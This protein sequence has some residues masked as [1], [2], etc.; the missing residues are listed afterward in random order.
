MATQHPDNAKKLPWYPRPI[1]STLAELKECFLCFKDL[2]I[3]EYNWDWEGKF[4]D[5]AVVDRLLHNQ[6]NYFSQ[7]PLGQEKF[8]TFRIPNPR[9]ESQFRLARAFM[10]AIT[11]SQHAKSLG[12]DIP[13]IFEAI[14]PLT[15]T[16][17]DIL[18][19][20]EAFVELVG[21]RHPLLKMDHSIRQLEIIPLFE[22]VSI[23]INS[24]D[25]LRR[26]LRLYKKR[27][28][29][30][31]KYI[32]PYIARSDPALNS[33]IVPTVLASKI[34]L[35]AYSKL[36]KESGVKMYPMIGTGSL[37]FRG[38]MNPDNI[39]N[40]I[41][42]YKGVATFTLQS[43]FRY[44]YPKSDVKKAVQFLKSHIPQSP[45]EV[46]KK[47]IDEIKGLLPEF[48]APYRQGVENLAPLI[49]KIS[50]NF[51]K[52]RERLQHIG[53]FG[54]SR[55]VGKVKLPRA[56]PFTGS[57]YSVGLPPEIISTGRALKKAKQKGLL[58]MVLK[59]YTHLQNDMINA[60]YFLNI[61]NAEKI[62]KKGGFWQELKED[63]KNI[64]DILCIELEPIQDIHKEHK[65]A[66]DKIY[67]NMNNKSITN[68]IER[69]GKHRRSLG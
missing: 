5:E 34:A 33:G 18:N 48:E 8:L 28:K 27:F 3:D 1:V 12:F 16:A 32:R 11:S 36:E 15:E 63:I 22:Q 51:P 62:G 24:A 44:D 50:K 40:A 49:N 17:E 41:S 26:Y 61:E 14:L 46:T 55:G 20:Q 29:I 25:T 52:R 7:H 64:E 39:E 66:S 60:G 56:I 69:M 30:L 65:K 4:V 9:V 38:S 43:A 10:V 19:I 21:L 31:P 35:S 47:E 67:K 37:P 68:L 45:Q 23:I 53:L 42:E 57:L 2:D 13:P 58:D 59:H 54:Y 6:Y